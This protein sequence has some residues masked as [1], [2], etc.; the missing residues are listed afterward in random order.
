VEPA[1]GHLKADHRMNRCWL[2]GA[3]GDAIHA[4]LCA[5]GYNLR[6]L[7]RAIAERGITPL[8][9]C[10]W[11]WWCQES[12]AVAAMRRSRGFRFD[13]D[14]ARAHRWAVAHAVAG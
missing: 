6:W 3:T 13:L 9:L 12:A 7:L 5:A 4:V 2:P 11:A 10:L 1:I 8:F 14:G